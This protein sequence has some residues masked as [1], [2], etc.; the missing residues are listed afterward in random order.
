[1]K[2][3]IC[4]FSQE[5]LSKLSFAQWLLLLMNV[6]YIESRGMQQANQQIVTIILAGIF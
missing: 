2:K 4:V 3:E 5:L 1:M 6:L